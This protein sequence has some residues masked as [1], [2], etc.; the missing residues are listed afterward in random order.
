MIA[1]VKRAPSQP[2]IRTRPAEA[3]ERA[4]SPNKGRKKARLQPAG[5]RSGS[6]AASIL[7]YLSLP[8]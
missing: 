3:K 8:R 4:A 6:G 2:A 5:H 7:P 1:V